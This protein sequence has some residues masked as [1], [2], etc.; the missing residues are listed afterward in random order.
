MGLQSVLDAVRDRCSRLPGLDQVTTQP[1]AQ[2]PDNRMIVIT[3]VPGISS[4]S[5]HTGEQGHPL[6]AYPDKIIVEA[7][8]KIAGD[9]IGPAI[10][11]AMPMLESVIST[12]WAAY[13][14][15]RLS[16]SVTLLNA[17]DVQRFGG[18]G[19]GADQT[20]GFIAVMDILR[21]EE[22]GG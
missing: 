20:F 4:P 14:L 6:I 11:W 12:L 7:H 18:I 5:A 19:W 13:Y 17:I 15:D 21:L 8:Y 1:P 2:L 3:P 22:I 10:D 16:G 9:Q